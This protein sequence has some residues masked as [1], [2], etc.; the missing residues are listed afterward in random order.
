MPEYSCPR[1]GYK[2]SIRTHL[3]NHF[4]RKFPCKVILQN[5]TISECYLE[6]LGIE[7]IDN[8]INVHSQQ[9]VN[10]LNDYKQP[11]KLESQ[12]KVNN[13][14]DFSQQMNKN[15]KCRYCDKSF[16]F[17]QSMYRHMKNCKNKTSLINTDASFLL[18]SDKDN[19]ILYTKSQVELLI[20]K[21]REEFTQKETQNITI[22]NELRKQ[23]ESL[24]KNQ[25]SNNITYNTNIILNAFGKENISYISNDYIKGLISSGPVSCI[26]KL[27]QHIHFNPDHSENHN[28]KIPNKKEPYAKIYNG[29][30]WEISD[31]KQAIEE[32]TDKAY[33]ILNEHYVGGNDYMANFRIQY[34]N[35]SKK[36]TK[37]LTKDTEIMIINSQKSLEI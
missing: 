13:L 6:V 28:I 36:L 25:G 8:K 1:C 32:M 30:N 24:L 33:T 22:I 10:I 35:N 26:P 9:K 14:N 27:L 16:S 21:T 7:H 29:T 19:E 11:K 18:E 12:Q 17:K 15:T 31:R 20:N 37:R 23:V 5:K 34:E 4:S 3:Y 2:S